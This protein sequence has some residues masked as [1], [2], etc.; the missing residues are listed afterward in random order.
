MSG[1]F[2]MWVN[3]CWVTVEL[4]VKSPKSLFSSRSSGVWDF[5][6]MIV[7]VSFLLICCVV[8]ISCFLIALCLPGLWLWRNPVPSRHSS[9]PCSN[10]KIT[11]DLQCWYPRETRW[12]IVSSITSL[13]SF[14]WNVSRRAH[15][16]WVKSIATSSNITDSNGCIVN[17]SVASCLSLGFHS[18]TVQALSR[19]SLQGVRYTSP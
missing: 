12:L 10:W 6:D 2:S 4:W 17:N 15:S 11:S 9:P 13:N 14:L 1:F 7:N 18:H 19:Q 16:S 5:I 3:K 8:I